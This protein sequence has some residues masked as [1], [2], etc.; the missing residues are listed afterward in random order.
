MFLRR[1][2]LIDR[3]HANFRSEP[4]GIIM[5]HPPRSK[6]GAP[7]SA[8]E[9]EAVTSAFERRQIVSMAATWLLF[10]AAGLYGT[11]RVIRF[12][13]YGAFFVSLGL[14]GLISAVLSFRDQT[15]LLEPFIKRRDELRAVNERRISEG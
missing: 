7:I 1:Q 10:G 9:Y 14:A 2:D 4:D 3:F 11:Y 15:D 13:D 6:H 12:D 8:E 5:F